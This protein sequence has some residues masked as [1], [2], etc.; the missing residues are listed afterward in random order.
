MTQRL[1]IDGDSSLEKDVISKAV[2][3]T[4]TNAYNVALMRKNGNNKHRED[5]TALKTEVA[6]LTNLVKILIE[7]LDK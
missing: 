2:I 7:K 6:E 1:K 4:D 5:I 3:S